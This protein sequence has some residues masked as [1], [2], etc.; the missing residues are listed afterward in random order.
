MVP[1]D[2][3]LLSLE[4]GYYSII[5]LSCFDLLRDVIF[6]GLLIALFLQLRYLDFTYCFEILASLCKKSLRRDLSF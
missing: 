3:Q 4:P 2:N 5:P 1:D 6:S